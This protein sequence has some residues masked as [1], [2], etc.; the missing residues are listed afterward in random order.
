[1]SEAQV[2]V[3]IGGQYGSEG[4]GAFIHWL[5]SLDRHIGPLACVRTGGPNAGHSIIHKGRVHKMQQIPVAWP[6]SFATLLIGP[7]GVID[8]DILR[9]EILEVEEVMGRGYLT[10]R[11]YIDPEAVIVQSRDHEAERELVQGIGSTGEGVGSATAQRV[12]R[13]AQLAEDVEALNTYRPNPYP[14]VAEMLHN[15]HEGGTP[16]YVESTQGFGLSL[17]RSGNYPTVTSRDLTPGAILNEA[18]IPHNW[19]TRVIAVF[20]TY[21][22]RV[23]GPS[24]VMLGGEISWE[25]LARR[26]DGYIKPEQTTVTKKTRRVAEW[27]AEEVQK[28]CLHLQ[29]DAA[30]LSFFD[31][32][33]PDLAGAVGLDAASMEKLLR[34][35]TFT[36]FDNDILAPIKWLGTGFGTILPI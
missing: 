25:E 24:G 19:P 8:L 29:P 32:V 27:S 13:T 30:Y 22:I 20:R 5:T 6:N 2:T 17:T 28:A 1:M 7:G 12:M 3:I 18:G 15:I 11:L 23:A 21:P 34:S 26:T 16:I 31:Y 4:K 36:R 33:R 9:R 35:P 14:S 10:G